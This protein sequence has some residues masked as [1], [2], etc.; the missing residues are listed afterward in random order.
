MRRYLILLLVA[1]LIA[2]CEATSIIVTRKQVEITGSKHLAKTSYR[3]LVVT[4]Y[5]DNSADDC[6]VEVDSIT[7][8]SLN[9]CDTLIG[10][11]K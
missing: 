3:V 9:L 4:N 1:F 5:T 10:F 8:Y 2:S 11:R 6:W 7:F